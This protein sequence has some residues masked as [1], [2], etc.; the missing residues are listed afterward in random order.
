MKGALQRG[1]LGLLLATAIG[2]GWAAEPRLLI[3]Y[4]DG[5]VARQAAELLSRDLMRLGWAV[6]ESKVGPEHPVALRADDE[7][8][9]S[10]IVAL[11]A[12]AFAASTRQA[13]GR[14]VVGALISRSALDEALPVAL[15]RWSVVL[16][17]QPPERWANLLHLALP[18]RQQIGMLVGPTALNKSQQLARRLEGRGMSLAMERVATAE[19]VIPAL[20]R[21]LLRTN[22]LLALPDPLTHNRGTVQAVLLT[23]YRARVPVVAYS[24]AY[25]QA[26]AVLALYSTVPQIVAQVVEALRQWQEGKTPAN[27]QS[28][29]YFT[30]GVNAAV[31]RSLGLSLPDAHELQERLRSLDQ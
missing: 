25:Q 20:D 17:D 2:C 26:G 11:G 30:V 19:E 31:A 6:G 1:L 24:E 13:G 8:G 15:P 27:V 12:R 21:L 5:P 10:A 3:L 14:A 18:N 9:L 16:L 22:T 29:R 4:E 7:P 23:T 28:P